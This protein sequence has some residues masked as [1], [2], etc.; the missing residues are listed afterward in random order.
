MSA[1]I[2]SSEHFFYH[3][4]CIPI[5]ATETKMEYD[6]FRGNHSSDDDFNWINDMFKQVLKEDKQLCEATYKNLQGGVFTNGELHPRAE[7]VS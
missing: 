4:R 2:H 3:M 5:S 6:V 1:V 7:N